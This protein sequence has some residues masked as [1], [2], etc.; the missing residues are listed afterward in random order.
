MRQLALARCKE[1]K[2]EQPHNGDIEQRQHASQPA[3]TKDI[4]A[5]IWHT[6][7]S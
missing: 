4:V 5:P 3:L 2:R 7:C 1:C 6:G